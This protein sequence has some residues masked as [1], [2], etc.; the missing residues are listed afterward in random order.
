[1]NKLIKEKY[2]GKLSLQCRIEMVKEEFLN[3]VVELNDT[4]ET[5]LEFVPV[6]HAFPLMLLRGTPLHE[7]KAE[8]GLV[9][10]FEIALTEIDRV[11][12][13]I[14]HV[15]A[16]PS[17]TYEEWKEMSK[18]AESLECSIKNISKSS[19]E[20]HNIFIMRIIILLTI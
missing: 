14:P 12:T 3:K 5:V 9:E 10:S 6:I 1:M 4:A 2:R 16:S 15:V 20:N 18:I 19:K 13:D 7:R 8:L 11:Q 17:F